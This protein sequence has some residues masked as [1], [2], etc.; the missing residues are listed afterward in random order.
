MRGRREITGGCALQRYGPTVPVYGGSCPVW[1]YVGCDARLWGRDRHGRAPEVTSLDASED[2][3]L[4]THGLIGYLRPEAYHD[5][6]W[7]TLL[8]ATHRKWGIGGGSE[9]RKWGI[10]P[11]TR[12]RKWGIGG[13]DR[14][15]QVCTGCSSGSCHLKRWVLCICTEGGYIWAA[16][17]R[18][19]TVDRPVHAGQEVI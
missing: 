5:R 18:I 11:S 17:C 15:S 1:L 12:N 19:T 6:K 8:D 2:W 14:V 3:P 16:F 9:D 10:R 13:P 4:R 7:G